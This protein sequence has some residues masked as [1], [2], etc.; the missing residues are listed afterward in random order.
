MPRVSLPAPKVTLPVIEPLPLAGKLR[1]LLPARS[2]SGP[3]LPLSQTKLSLP[4][5]G[6]RLQAALAGS[7][8]PM[9]SQ[10]EMAQAL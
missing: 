4:G 6:V 7:D 3:L 1:L 2:V 10:M 9:Q 8:Q 5:E